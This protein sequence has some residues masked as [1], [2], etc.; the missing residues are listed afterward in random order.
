MNER[1]LHATFE[2]ESPAIAAD[3]LLDTLASVWLRAIYET[4]SPPALA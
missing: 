3:A 1:V 2:G 4:G